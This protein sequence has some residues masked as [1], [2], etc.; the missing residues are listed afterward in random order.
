[1]ESRFTR[2]YVFGLVASQIVR[3]LDNSIIRTLVSLS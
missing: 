1:M 3:V 2:K